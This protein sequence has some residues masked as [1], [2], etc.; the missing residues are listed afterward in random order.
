M[1]DP[2]KNGPTTHQFNP[3]NIAREYANKIV[4]SDNI[5]KRGYNHNPIS[6]RYGTPR[7]GGQSQQ[8]GS[9]NSGK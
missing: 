3:R 1:S 8:S 5:E 4:Q 9:Q 7:R 6:D 2:K